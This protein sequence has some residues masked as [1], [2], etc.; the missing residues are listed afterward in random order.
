[1]QSKYFSKDG[2]VV[3]ST[4]WTARLRRFTVPRPGFR[5][6]TLALSL[7]TFLLKS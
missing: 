3:T 1:M 7:F 4:G 6:S 5:R 2:A